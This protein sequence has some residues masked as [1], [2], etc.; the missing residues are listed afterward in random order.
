MMDFRI[1]MILAIG[2][3]AIST[4]SFAKKVESNDS[5]TIQCKID[6]NPANAQEK[7][8]YSLVENGVTILKKELPLSS[9]FF[10]S[11][12][13]TCLQAG[14][15]TYITQE[16]STG[17]PYVSNKSIIY[18][19]QLDTKGRIIN[20]I[21]PFKGYDSCWDGGV[22][23]S[24]NGIEMKA[25]CY[26]KNDRV[27]NE[28]FK[29][30]TLTLKNLILKDQPSEQKNIIAAIQ[31]CKFS[32]K[33]DDAKLINNAYVNIKGRD[34]KVTAPKGYFQTSIQSCFVKDKEYEVFL[35]TDTQRSESLNQTF[36]EK[37]IFNVT[38]DVVSR[39]RI[40][41]PQ[42]VDIWSCWDGVLYYKDLSRYI[43]STCSYREDHEKA[44][45]S[46]SKI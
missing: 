12:I 22:S 16:I 46:I 28:I 3:A 6:N 15:Y 38:G 24:D 32:N 18:V 1:S 36:L 43:R 23:L 40:P 11:K 2:L 20:S 8:I 41:G 27:A 37:A 17:D 9:S 44:F 34:I 5:P 39:L 33:Y 14:K 25:I 10:N 45:F 29:T 42:N 26:K 19:H 21:E 30:S 31:N 7:S 13:D 4:A 35:Q